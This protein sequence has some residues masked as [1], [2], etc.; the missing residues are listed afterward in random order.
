MDKMFEL[1]VEKLQESLYNLNMGATM[2]TKDLEEMW[3]LLHHL[4]YASYDSNSGDL[5]YQLIEYYG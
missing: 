3:T 2:S 5:L 4:H 1:L